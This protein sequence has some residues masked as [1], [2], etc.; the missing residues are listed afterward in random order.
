MIFMVTGPW[1]LFFFSTNCN[2]NA[3][4][5]SRPNETDFCTT[6]V[7][8]FL[9]LQTHFYTHRLRLAKPRSPSKFSMLK[10]CKLLC[11][12]TFFS[13][14]KDF[15][16]RVDWDKSVCGEIN[17]FPFLVCRV[18]GILQEEGALGR[19]WEGW[20]GDK[21]EP[22]CDSVCY[23]LWKSSKDSKLNP[24]MRLDFELCQMAPSYQ[25]F[26]GQA[27]KTANQITHS[28]QFGKR[29]DRQKGSDTS[30][31]I[32]VNI[33]LCCFSLYVLCQMHSQY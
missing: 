13:H 20:R 2:T 11:E 16:L 29:A 28:R 25:G 7:G 12:N 22:L 19:H 31:L 3:T 24:R 4:V 8:A 6:Y 23:L 9:L 18:G 10:S 5:S 26:L 30:P 1:L 21:L 14:T 27:N 33:F 17:W 32:S 15:S